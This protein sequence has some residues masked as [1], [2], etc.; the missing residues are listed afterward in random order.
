MREHAA[1]AVVTHPADEG[2]AAAEAGAAD[3]GGG[4]GAA[5]RPAP[6]PRGSWGR[7]EARRGFMADVLGIRLKPEVL[8]L[9]N[10]AGA[11]PPYW[12]SPNRIVSKA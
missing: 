3:D 8:P 6:R 11:M 1:E 12:L 7:I 5:W 10:L 9:S 2:G 4:G